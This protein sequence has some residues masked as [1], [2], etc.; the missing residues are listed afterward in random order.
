MRNKINLFVILTLFF[1]GV[2]F[3]INTYFFSNHLIEKSEE[4]YIEET[5]KSS[6][7]KNKYLEK[8][9]EI[10]KK[11]II[12]EE[13]NKIKLEEN[14]KK[15][16]I[17]EEKIR[18][19]LREN[20]YKNIEFSAVPYDFLEKEK[21][22]KQEIKTI[23]KNDNI[24]SLLKKIEIIF[25][26]E[27]G[28]VRWKMKNR[29]VKLFAPQTMKKDELIAIFIH[30]FSHYIDIY[31]LERKYNRDISDKFYN[32]AW[33]STKI[34]K[35]WLKWKDFVSGYSMT[36]KYE[37]FAESLTYYILHN[38]DFLEKTRKSE[39]LREKYNFFSFYIFK[40]WLFKN[41]DFSENNEIKD[42]YR[43]ITKIHFSLNKFLYYLRKY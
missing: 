16:K 21:K 34:I 40:N 27:K 30:E 32:I 15:A 41:T 7:E 42:Y 36:N 11:S 17:R 3:L 19:I 1:T 9:K 25:Y 4:N 28:E 5:L 14:K 26:E 18:Q 23:L 35:P 31:S 43:D 37:D 12:K 8:A 20:K 29:V 24:F 22:E 10:L 39:I 38:K 6:D 13:K 33:Y 2:I